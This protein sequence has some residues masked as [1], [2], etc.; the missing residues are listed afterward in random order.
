M[1]ARVARFDLFESPEA[2]KRA[3]AAMNS[4]AGRTGARQ[5]VDLY[6]V[7]RYNL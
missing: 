3:D 4:G 7:P 5:S 1:W 6:E 2:M